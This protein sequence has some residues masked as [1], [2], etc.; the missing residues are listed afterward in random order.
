MFSMFRWAIGITA[1]YLLFLITTTPVVA[2][3]DSLRQFYPPGAKVYPQTPNGLDTTHPVD[4]RKFVAQWHFETQSDSTITRFVFDDFVSNGRRVWLSNWCEGKTWNWDKTTQ[5]YVNEVT[6]AQLSSISHTTYMP[7]IAG[8]TIGFYRH[9]YWLRRGPSTGSLA[10]YVSGDVV[11]YSV[12]L[13]RKSDGQRMALLDT[14]RISQSGASSP[15]VYMW[16][17][18]ASKVRYVI[19][20][21]ISDT[22]YACVRVNVYTSGSDNDVFSRTDLFATLN[23]RIF[24]NNPYF[25]NFMATVN[26]ENACGAATGGCGMTVTNGTSGSVNAAVTSSSITLVKAFSQAG[27][28]VSST[29]VTTW[30]STVALST[31]AGLY[32]VCGVNSSGTVVCTNTMLVP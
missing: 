8:D 31:G 28:L 27:Y 9:A 22:T 7:V 10:K 4:P 26:S 20:S 6:N 2:Q 12:E 19:P 1:V 29:A 21:V 11:S 30:P 3:C 18:L 15:C 24:L 23:A 17:P 16:Y 5:Q 32:I 25:E 13:V 14:V